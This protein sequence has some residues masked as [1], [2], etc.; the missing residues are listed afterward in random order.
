MVEPYF[1][2]A[3]QTQPGTYLVTGTAG[4]IG[5]RVAG[6]LLE[7]GHRVVGIDNLAPAYDIR[8]K[9]WRLAQVKKHPGFT[10]LPFDISE[11]DSVVEIF[12]KQQAQEGRPFTA[13]INLA[14]RAGVRASIENPA[15][16][17]GTNITGTLNLLNACRDFG[18]NK[19]ILS[20]TSSLYG[21]GHPAPYVESLNTER[22]LSPYAATKKAAEVLCYTYHYLYKIDMTIFRYFTVYGPA[23]RPDMMPFKFVQRIT[24]GRAIPVFGD[25][26]QS[27]DFTYVDDI[28]RGT[29]LGLKPV[30]YEVVNLGSD[31]PI[32][33]S[34][35]IATLERLIGKQAVIERLPRHP[36]DVV[37]TWA[38]I[39]K[40]KS[41]LGW[42]PQVSFEQG[43]QN[44]INWYNEN[45]SWA[46]DIKT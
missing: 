3:A 8:I 2:A 23:G 42:K 28:A 5:F 41:L 21:E 10:Y 11:A 46:S 43:I 45:R 6:M 17:V 12:K 7:A 32:I 24:E 13:V 16:Y 33:L 27:R 29:I 1:M 20:S 25:G 4:F 38:N 44:T 39:D 18:T 9:E 36:A 30:G 31:E 35:A 19:F 22:M 26:K 15:V 34:D 14:A 37:S 40:A